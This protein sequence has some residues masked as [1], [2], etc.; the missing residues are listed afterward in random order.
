[1]VAA[2]MGRDAYYFFR[3]ASRRVVPVLA[4][5]QETIEKQLFRVK[6]IAEGAVYL[7]GGRAAGLKEGQ[8][9]SSSAPWPRPLSMAAYNRPL[10]RQE[11]SLR[12]R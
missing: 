4:W 9:S 1:M 8:S 3:T 5:A 7:E 12:S 2:V 11:S 6:Y 10:R